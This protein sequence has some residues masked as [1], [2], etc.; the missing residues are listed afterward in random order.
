MFSAACGHA[1]RSG[2]PEP[3]PR[4]TLRVENQNFLD[5]DVFVL[6]DGLRIRIGMVA[7]LSTQT[8]TLRDEIVRSSSQ[9]RFELHPIGG[10]AN[11][12]TETITV[13]PGDEIRLTIPPS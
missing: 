10:R 6:R 12:R 11:P 13:Q 8:F 1:A 2:L 4:T 3:Q 7:G 5:M 9:L